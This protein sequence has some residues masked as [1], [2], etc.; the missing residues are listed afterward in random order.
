MHSNSRREFL[1]QVGRGMLVAGVGYTTAFDLGLTPALADENPAALT[2]GAREALVRLLQDTPPEKLLPLVVSRLKSGLELRELVAAAALANA[3]TF[4]GEDYV[5]FHTMM[6]LVPSYEMAKELPASKQAL[7]VLKVLYRNTNRCQEHGGHDSE[8]LHQLAASTPLSGNRD[9]FALREAVRNKDL[10]A[11]ERILASAVQSSPLDGFNLLLPAIEDCFDVHRIVMPHRAWQ[12]I[13]LVGKENAE[14]MLRQSV[15]YCVNVEKNQKFVEMCQPVRDVLASLLDQYR[16][17]SK[18]LGTRTAED[19]PLEALSQ[20]IFKSTPA[21]AA[22]A[23]AAALAEGFSPATVSE[24]VSLAGNQ[25]VLRDSGRRANQVSKGKPEGSVHGD[26][27][28]V[29]AC[30]TINAWRNM[31]LVAN[32][33]NAAACL[34]MAAYQVARDRTARNEDFGAWQPYPLAEHYQKLHGTSP[35]ELLKEADGAI[36]ENDQARACAAVAR[37]GETGQS[38]RPVFDLML[39]YAISEDGALHAEKY[40][41]TVTEEFAA[42]RPAFRWRQLLALARVTASEYGHPAPGHSEAKGL[43]GVS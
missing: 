21:Q 33:R 24:A 16:L 8:V 11:A 1:Q 28:G 17:A 42:T 3:R 30:D 22:E 34:I 7:P 12:L 36:R 37:Y 39:K 2:F 41:R 20:T 40:Y 32:Q 29:H 14:T 4:G 6:A 26:S 31:A 10:S 13:D 9:E 25:L 18:P 15:H 5:G 38:A 27:I 19:G 43:L 35:D 23:A